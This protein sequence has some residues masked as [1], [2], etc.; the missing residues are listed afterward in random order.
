MK[1]ETESTANDI[2]H[3]SLGAAVTDHAAAAREELASFEGLK[4]RAAQ[5]PE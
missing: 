4:R 3:K 1:T 2:F 5:C